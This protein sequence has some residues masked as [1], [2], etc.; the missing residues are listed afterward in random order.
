ML[1]QEKIQI[2]IGLILSLLIVSCSSVKS[3]PSTPTPNKEAIFTQASGTIITQYTQNALLATKT[4]VPTLVEPTRMP[5][6]ANTLTPS[7]SPTLTQTL[8]PTLSPEDPKANLGKA[9]WQASFK[10]DRNWY[11]F[12]TDQTSIQVENKTLVLKSKKTNSY[13]NW[14]MSWPVLSDFYLEITA[15]TGDACQGKDRYGLIIRAPDPDHGYLFGVSCDGFYRVRTWD[16]ENFDELIAWQ[17][18]GHIL[19]G[20]NQTNRLGIMAEG[21]KLTIFVNGH[22]LAEVQDKTYPKG[23]FGAFIASENTPDFSVV[24]SEAAYWDIP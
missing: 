3:T 1:R 19:T 23:A 17:H 13:E 10:D 4:P 11:T 12:E 21:A 8:I 2:L 20:P 5:E 15:N 7:P 9:A 22:L 14:S 6:I 16:G 24:I 18:S